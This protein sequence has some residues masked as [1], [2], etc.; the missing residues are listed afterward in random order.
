LD[1]DEIAGQPLLLVNPLKPVS[2][3]AVFQA[4]D[5]IDRGALDVADAWPASLQGRNDLQAAA[6]ANCQEIG[7][8]MHRLRH[9]KDTKLVRMSGS[10]ATCFAIFDSIIA[11]DE[12]QAAISS[13]CPHWWTMASSLR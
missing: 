3:A 9:C 11:R 12:S 2:T 6:I 1:D 13:A 10:G 5:R 7:A 8:V 4:W